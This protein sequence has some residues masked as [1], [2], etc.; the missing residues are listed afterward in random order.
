MSRAGMV[1]VAGLVSS[2][3]ACGEVGAPTGEGYLDLPADQVLIGATHVFSSDGLRSAVGVFDTVYVFTDSSI[4]HLRGVNLTMYDETGRQTSTVTSRSGTMNVATDA[5]MAE[6]GVVLITSD[7]QKIETEQLHYDPAT[8]RVWSDVETKRTVEGRVQIG[9]SFSADD[10]FTRVV[11]Q[12]PRGEVTG[13]R[14][15][16]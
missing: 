14:I 2:A 9:D 8:R 3:L 11:I 7:L 6:G 5:M 12:N 4:Y 15:Q 13:I 16:R 10:Q 1:V